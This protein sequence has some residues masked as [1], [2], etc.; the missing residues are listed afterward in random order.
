MGHCSWPWYDECIA[1]YGKFL[2]GVANDQDAPEMFFDLT[3]GTPRIYRED[4]L[5]K[6]FTVG[7]G[8][9][10]ANKARTAKGS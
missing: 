10:C 7:D 5:T 2:N 6:L 8:V 3:P 9:D 4:L 1:V